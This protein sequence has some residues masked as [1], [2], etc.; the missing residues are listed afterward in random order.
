MLLMFLAPCQAK[1]CC[2]LNSLWVRHVFFFFMGHINIQATHLILYYSTLHQSNIGMFFVI[3]CFKVP[4]R[5]FM[6]FIIVTFSL[7]KQRRFQVNGAAEQLRP[8][9]LGVQGLTW[10]RYS[11]SLYFLQFAWLRGQVAAECSDCKMQRTR[12][13]Q[14]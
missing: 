6:R 10:G 5:L 1:A 12:K 11:I 3:G 9:V 14:G 8:A 4:C 2:P 7:K 13:I